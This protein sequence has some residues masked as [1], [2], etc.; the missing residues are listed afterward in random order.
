[1]SPVIMPVFGRI[2]SVPPARAPHSV[3]HRLTKESEMSK[4]SNMHTPIHVGM[5]PCLFIVLSISTRSFP[6][7]ARHESTLFIFSVE[8]YSLFPCHLLMSSPFPISKWAPCALF[9]FPKNTI[10]PQPAWYQSQL[11]HHSTFS[12]HTFKSSVTPASEN[13]IPYFPS[14][15]LLATIAPVHPMNTPRVP[16][17]PGD[18]EIMLALMHCHRAIN[19]LA[20][21]R[22]PNFPFLIRL[23]LSLACQTPL[24]RDT[25]FG[26]LWWKTLSISSS[27]NPG[28]TTLAKTASN[29]SSG[30]S[31]TP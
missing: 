29:S 28:P 4:V 20:P 5:L 27:S 7:P 17:F 2:L 8:K 21:P 10:M 6:A 12:D 16:S 3:R 15:H 31:A 30:S 18:P 14:S 1:M 24:S 19:N 22:P 23:C 11:P 26:T 9:S 25:A 13:D